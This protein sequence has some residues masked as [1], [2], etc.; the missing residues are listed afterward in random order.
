MGVTSMIDKQQASNTQSFTALIF[1]IWVVAGLVTPVTEADAEEFQ[2][3]VRSIDEVADSA[4]PRVINLTGTDAA[5]EL[6]SSIALAC[7][8]V[9]GE[10]HDFGRIAIDDDMD[11]G[12]HSDH[13]PVLTGLSPETEYFFRVQGTS[14]D[15][16]IYVGQVQ[17]FR[18]P[19]RITGGPVNLA[20]LDA[21][22]SVRAVSSNYGAGQNNEAWGADS[23]IDGS[24]SS[25]WS[26]AG[27]GD[28]AFIEIER[29]SDP[30][31]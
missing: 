24:R 15:G 8:V 2:F 14:P 12:A 4:M 9:F 23:A 27:D 1:V 28:D 20:S 16:R 13:H 22:A 31:Q 18:T 21:G 6:R 3:P 25:A 26:S 5:I 10:T 17:R 30:C 29:R 19:S 7:S 11:G